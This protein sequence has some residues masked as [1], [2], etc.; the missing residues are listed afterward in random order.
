M[1][2]RKVGIAAFLVSLLACGSGDEAKRAETGAGVDTLVF[3]PSVT[4]GS[5]SGRDDE[6]LV[7]A[8]SGF[9][10]SQGI[11]IANRNPPEIREYDTAGALIRRMGREG[12]GPG[13]FRHLT[14]IAPWGGDSIAALDAR[15]SRITVFSPAGAYVRML[16]LE[17]LDYG[18]VEW[19]G[20]NGTSLVVGMSQLVDPRQL[21]VGG[22]AR[23]SFTLAFVDRTGAE[24]AGALTGS[25]RIGGRWWRRVASADAVGIA[26]VETGPQPLVAASA[27]VLIVSASDSPEVLR[28]NGRQWDTV[29]VHRSLPEVTDQPAAQR[30]TQLAAG[31]GGEIWLADTVV[32]ASGSREWRVL[33]QHGAL[34]A[35][36]RLPAR[37]TVWQVGHGWVLGRLLGEDD[38][39]YVQLLEAASPS[40]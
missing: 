20:T 3:R 8:F 35:V 34:R 2:G 31:P 18:G 40:T 16:G 22:L 24:V 4:I 37:F 13:E 7:R 9:R 6:V 17:A 28:W 1:T 19:L 5:V 10:S 33:N 39:E 32:A 21:P 30:H 12:A 23:D 36:T 38:V 27:G 14:W 11:V 29:Q 26:M 25:G 15:L